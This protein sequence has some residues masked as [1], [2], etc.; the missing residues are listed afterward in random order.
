[1]PYPELSEIKKIAA[2]GRYNIAPVTEELFA[3]VRTP[4]EVL[5]AMM[6][7][8]EHV[9]ILESAEDKEKW[10]RYTFLGFDPSMEITCTNGVLCVD[11]KEKMHTDRPEDFIRSVLAKRKSPKI[12][13][14]PSFTG[15]LVGYFS[16]DYLK[17]PE[18]SL[19]LDAKDT[20][21]FRDLDLMLF[22][23][24]VAFDNFSQKIVLIV[25]I[26]LVKDLDE[27]Y[28][29]AEKKLAELK[30]L[31]LHGEPKKDV[32]GR[33]TSEIRPYFSKEQYCEMVEKAK[34]HIYEGDIFQIVLS[35]H[36]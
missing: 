31:I 5:K 23:N 17:Y 7:V 33:M 34:H 24:V 22:D 12:K 29:R 19:R 21:G 14:L 6:N 32:N 35:T 2:D 13:G 25:N 8:S 30:E 18:P 11:G 4:V 15:G 10:G 20:E 16:Y 28:A 36:L 27:E 1:M 3:D 9:F 26:S